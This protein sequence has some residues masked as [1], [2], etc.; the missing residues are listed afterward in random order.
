MAWIILK[1][2]DDPRHSLEIELNLGRYIFDWENLIKNNN[3][4]QTNKD[5]KAS[6]RQHQHICIIKSVSSKRDYDMQI[7]LWGVQ[8]NKI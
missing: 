3:K 1:V 8:S 7:F 2:M 5:T 6:N 4:T